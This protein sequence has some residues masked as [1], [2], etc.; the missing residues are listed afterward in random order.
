MPERRSRAIGEF[1]WLGQL[2]R[3]FVGG[4]IVDVIAGGNRKR[5]EVFPR[6]SSLVLMGCLDGGSVSGW[7]IM[8]R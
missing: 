6:R 5:G 2:R 3:W 1:D 8:V 7:R 4:E